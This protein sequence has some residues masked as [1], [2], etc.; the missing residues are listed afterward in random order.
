MFGNYFRTLDDK[1][2]VIVPS[3][4][5]DPLGRICYITLG[6]DKVLEIRDEKSFETFKDKLMSPNML[7]ANARKFA[8]IL[9]GNTHEVELD[10]SGRIALPENILNQAG[11]TKDVVFVGVGNKVE[12]WDKLSFEN[13]SKQ[14]EGEGSLDEL[15]EKLLRD[16]VEL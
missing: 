8:R 4:L 14:F 1:N 7:N 2:R 10:K 5:R 9:L 12:L 6:P 16:G 3:K 13:F 15:A 11:I